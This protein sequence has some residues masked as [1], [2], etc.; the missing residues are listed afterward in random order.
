LNFLLEPD[1]ILLEILKEVLDMETFV[2]H[3]HALRRCY[4]KIRENK[5]HEF[6][7][8]FLDNFTLV[9]EFYHN[10]IRG[11]CTSNPLEFLSKSLDASIFLTCYFYSRSFN[12]SSL[13]SPHFFFNLVNSPNNSIKLQL[14]H[15]AFNGAYSII[16]KE[17]LKPI[18]SL[19]D[20]ESRLEVA[21]LHLRAL[22]QVNEYCYPQDKV[23]MIPY[24]VRS[25]Q[26]I[27]GK[28]NFL[29]ENFKLCGIKVD[30]NAFVILFNRINSLAKQLKGKYNVTRVEKLIS[31]FGL[32]A[33]HFVISIDDQEVFCSI[34]PKL[35]CLSVIYYCI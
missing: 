34:S 24:K 3:F 17:F 23:L 14:A 21:R 30:A 1:K 20:W 8:N 5:N 12:D 16:S 35:L 26:F 11:L 22:L 27:I 13:R 6:F 25:M 31:L 19:A 15:I 28:I 29:I 2:A 7:A 4:K 32:Y 33:D 18:Q 9:A 10:S